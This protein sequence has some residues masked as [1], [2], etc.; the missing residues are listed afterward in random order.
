MTAVQDSVL[1]VS[2]TQWETSV[3]SARWDI[4]EMQRNAIAENAHATSLAQTVVSVQHEMI[5]CAI[6]TV[7]SASAYLESLVN[8]VTAALLTSGTWPVGKDVS[9]A[10]VTHR[11]Q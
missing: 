10:T 5:A 6:V 4:M 1:S 7:A 3:I 9:H 11:I 2:T 8:T